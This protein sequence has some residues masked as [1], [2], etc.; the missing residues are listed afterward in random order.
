LHIKARLVLCW[1]THN[2]S[3]QTPKMSFFG[4]W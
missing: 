2:S 3:N 4:T 1:L